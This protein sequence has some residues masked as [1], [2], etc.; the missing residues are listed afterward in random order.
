MNAHTRA[1]AGLCR[2]PPA[3][4]IKCYKLRGLK[5]QE[6]P[7][8]SGGQGPRLVQVGRAGP[9]GGSE[10]N[11]FLA[12]P[13]LMAPFPISKA[14]KVASVQSSIVPAPPA[15]TVTVTCGYGTCRISMEASPFSG[16]QIGSLPSTLPQNTMHSQPPGVPAAGGRARSPEHAQTAS[17]SPMPGP[18]DVFTWQGKKGWC[19]LG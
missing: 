16:W 9:S 8:Q 11:L 2:S 18:E 15:P 4:V 12:C 19:Q 3:A 5:Q 6:L 14:G 7:P 17:R 10:R 1:W 13:A